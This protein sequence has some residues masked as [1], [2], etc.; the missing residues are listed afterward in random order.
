MSI[1]PAHAFSLNTELTLLFFFCF[2][3]VGRIYLRLTLPRKA[4]SVIWYQLTRASVHSHGVIPVPLLFGA[5][6]GFATLSPCITSSLRDVD[7]RPG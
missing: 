4:A 7:E 1:D 6:S 2:F 5:V 3:A